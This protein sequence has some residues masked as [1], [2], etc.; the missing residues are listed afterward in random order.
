VV[1]DDLDRGAGTFE[2]RS[3]LLEAADDRQ[4]FLVVD[5]VVT[6]R[7][8]VFLGEERNRPQDAVV[9]ILR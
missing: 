7:Y 5:L 9:S 4:E 3:P 2:L 8:R 6:L 1:G